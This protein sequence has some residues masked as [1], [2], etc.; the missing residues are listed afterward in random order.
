MHNYDD[1]L[2]PSKAPSNVVTLPQSKDSATV[3][4][5][6]PPKSSW[7]GFIRKYEVKVEDV[8]SGAPANSSCVEVAGIS[9]DKMEY[10]ISDLSPGTEYSVQVSACTSAGSG[11]WSDPPSKFTTDESG[12]FLTQSVLITLV[13]CT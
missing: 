3:T 7:N 2:E 13:D 10:A 9:H 11:K 6:P 12:M 1:F 4:W 5:N 8:F